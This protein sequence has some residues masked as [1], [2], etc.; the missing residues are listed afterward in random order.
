[1]FFFAEMLVA[2]ILKLKNWLIYLRDMIPKNPSQT[3]YIT[4]CIPKSLGA[5]KT[6]IAKQVVWYQ[7]IKNYI[8][9]HIPDFTI[10][11]CIH[12]NS[13]KPYQK[14][15]REHPVRMHWTA[16][17]PVIHQGF[18]QCRGAVGP[19]AVHPQILGM[20]CWQMWELT[21]RIYT[22]WGPQTIAKLV[23]ITSNNSNSYGLWYLYVLITS[24]NYTY[25]GLWTNL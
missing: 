4:T 15:D 20:F 8:F 1:M 17:A 16:P 12:L 9:H 2:L 19:D 10:L 11:A 5:S 21:H 3:H 13:L 23:Q 14:F 18:R 22:K 6:V 25:R 24:Y 7:I